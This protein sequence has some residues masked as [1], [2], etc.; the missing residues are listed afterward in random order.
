MSLNQISQEIKLEAIGEDDV[1]YILREVSRF[2]WWQVTLYP[3]PVGDITC[4]VY[5]ILNGM[6]VN[7]VAY[8][9][10]NLI[11]HTIA[12]VCDTFLI[13]VTGPAPSLTARFF[14]RN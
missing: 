11:Q 1:Y 12:A 4:N 2:T 6:I 5:E 8:G 14:G 7:T 9:P 13:E 10:L 3:G